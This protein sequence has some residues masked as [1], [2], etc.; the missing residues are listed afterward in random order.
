[1]FLNS[2]LSGCFI[3]ISSLASHKLGCL[4]FINPLASHIYYI[5]TDIASCTYYK[6]FKSFLFISGKSKI[7]SDVIVLKEFLTEFSANSSFFICLSNQSILDIFLI[8]CILCTISFKVSASD[9][10]LFEKRDVCDF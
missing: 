10:N 5:C 2:L 3:F 4:I 1:M 7:S 9:C 6:I 8:L